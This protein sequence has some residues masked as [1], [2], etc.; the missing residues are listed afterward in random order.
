[1]SL[2]FESDRCTGCQACQMACLDQRD[3][4]PLE[5]Q[6]PLLRVEPAEEPGWF[7]A[8]YCT[9]CGACAEICPTGCL[10]KNGGV[11]TAEESLCIGCRACGDRNKQKGLAIPESTRDRQTFFAYER[12]LPFPGRG[13]E[14]GRPA[15]D[16][17][18]ST[19]EGGL[20]VMS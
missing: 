12:G 10:R 16:H 15:P 13:A 1:M 8:V 2:V 3:I 17:S 19:V 14:D 20:E 11:I 4:R 5:G 9:Q 18:Y 6:R 7:R